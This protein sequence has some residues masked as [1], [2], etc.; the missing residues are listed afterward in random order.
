MR[1]R[2]GVVVSGK[3]GAWYVTDLGTGT[4]YEVNETSALVLE[5]IRAGADEA[6]CVQALLD[7]YPDVPEDEVARDVRSLVKEMTAAGI[8]EARQ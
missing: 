3:Q 4:S 1:L 8:L 5:A 7:A 2:A 6:G